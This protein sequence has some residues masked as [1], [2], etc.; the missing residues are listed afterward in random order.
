[1]N[2]T[3]KV[4]GSR[5]TGHGS[6]IL[7]WWK[8][9]R[10]YA[11]P[12]SIMPVAVGIAFAWSQGIA[13][14][15]GWAILTLVGV[16]AAHTG[17]NLLNDIE[18][19]RRGVDRSGTLGGNGLLVDGTL[20]SRTILGAALISFGVAGIVAIPLILH[21]GAELLWLVAPG[22]V[23]AAGYVLPPLGLKYRALGDITVFLAFGVG[24]T[25]GSYSVQVGELSFA[26]AP[27]AVPLGLLVAAILHVNNMRDALDDAAVD[28]QTLAARMGPDRAKLFYLL[29][30]GGAYLVCALLVVAGVLLPGA[31]LAVITLPLA[32]STMVSV[33]RSRV[34]DAR[35]AEA[36]PRTAQLNLVFGGAL[37][38]GIVVWAAFA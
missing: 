38:G 14:R 32:L 31:L 12:A 6:R 21:V 36:V 5:V 19:Y 34:R 15:W 18:D 30:V 10:P 33:W 7:L 22:L 28:V 4:C 26:A 23:A 2:S 3:R 13:I 17:G 27:V 11:Y 9:V 8:A 24:I 25:V 20:T 35:L 37:V 29:L 16:V 1:M